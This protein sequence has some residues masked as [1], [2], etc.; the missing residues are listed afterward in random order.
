MIASLFFF[1]DWKKYEMARSLHTKVDKIRAG[2]REDLKS[3][4]MRIR[5]RAVAMSFIDKVNNYLYTYYKA[6]FIK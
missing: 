5:Q 6:L 2:Y 1:Q 3:K 4:E